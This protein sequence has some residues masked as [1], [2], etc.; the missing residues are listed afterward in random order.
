MKQVTISNPFITL[1][2]LD[3]GAIIQKLLVKDDEGRYTNVVVGYDYP[4]KYPND[5]RSLGAC[6]GR[7]AG[8]ISNGGFNLDWKNYPL[9]SVNGIHLHG[10]K[11]GFAKKYWTVEEIA[12]GDEP[13]VRLSYMSKHL[14][15]GYPGNLKATVTYK[16]RNNE[17]FIIHEATTDLTTVVNMTNHSYFKLD[18][19][20]SIDHYFLRLNCP[21]VLETNTNL[22]PTG[23]VLPVEGTE[24]DFKS[25]RQIGQTRLDTPFATDDNSS[26]AAMVY[27][28]KSGISMEV[29]TNQRGLVVYT[30]NSFPA[31]CF[32]TQNFPDAP[33]QPHFPSSVLRPNETYRN[34]T[35][36]KF[37]L[38]T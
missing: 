8:R 12:H 10:G 17:L 33:N 26:F 5:T 31:I 7:Y 9:P 3:Y 20:D 36:F 21:K 28:K 18:R 11:E 6:V 13:F 30:P 2:V 22:L 24:F 16:I 19:E 29:N 14:E 37:D 32:E 34:A 25:V 35:I 4:S 15:E 38:V 27:S 1:I 23:K